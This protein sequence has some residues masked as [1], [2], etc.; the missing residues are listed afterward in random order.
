MMMMMMMFT[1]I[2]YN[3]GV[4]QNLYSICFHKD[5]PERHKYKKITMIIRN[6]GI[7]DENEAENYIQNKYKQKLFTKNYV[8][9]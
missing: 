8:T 3:E 5:R 4:S 2:N 1:Y 6:K 9:K 7:Y